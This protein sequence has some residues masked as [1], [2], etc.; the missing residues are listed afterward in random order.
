[1]ANRRPMGALEDQ[2]MDYLWMIDDPVTPSEVHEA[3]APE[4]AYTTV[5]TVLS[6]L[7]DKGRLVRDR[8]GR[9]YAYSAVRSEAEH[10]AEEMATSLVDAGDRTAVLSQFVAS[11]DVDDAKTLRK[12]L[13]RSK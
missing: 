9:A 2:V 11:L 5:M 13:G 4:L 3:V 7:F 12:L 8:R 6:R 10:R 1:M